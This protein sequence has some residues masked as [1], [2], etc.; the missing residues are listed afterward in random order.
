MLKNQDEA[1][2]RPMLRPGPGAAGD[3]RPHERCESEEEK[4]K[5]RKLKEGRRHT[6]QTEMQCWSS[7]LGLFILLLFASH[8]SM[9]KAYY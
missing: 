5:T 8:P 6:S 7:N 9:F 2:C 4:E 3:P 1:D